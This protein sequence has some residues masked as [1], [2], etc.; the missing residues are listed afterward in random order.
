MNNQFKEKT[1][2]EWMKMGGKYR[3]QCRPFVPV[4]L[5]KGAGIYVWDVEGKRYIDFESGQICMSIGHSHPKISEAIV[6][7][8]NKIMQNGSNYTCVSE[9]LLAKKL[10]EITPEPF[11]KS[12]FACSGSEANEIALRMVKKYTGRFEI[13]AVMRNYHGSTFGSFAVSS[14]VNRVGYG[15]LMNGVYFIPAPYCYRCQFNECYPGCK[16]SCVDYA[17]EL[18]KRV[19]SGK[20]AA[21]I[22]ELL[23]SGGGVIVPPKEWI[24]K[25]RQICNEREMLMIA[26]EAQTGIGRTGKWFMCQHLDVTPDIITTSKSI[27]GGVP[28]SAVITSEEI[29]DTS[30]KNG[31]QYSSSHA[32]DP[33]L[34]A[35]GLAQIELIEQ[36]NLMNN[37]TKIENIMKKGLREL[38]EKY[39]VIGDVRGLGTLLGIEIVEDPV[40][41]K[42]AFDL[43]GRIATECL[44]RGLIVGCNPWRMPPFR[45][46]IRIV[47]P[48]ISKEEELSTALNIL[49]E[50]IKEAIK[51]KDLKQF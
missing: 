5:E 13:V 35:V 17:E 43:A 27:G 46:V 33:F 30:V 47:P 18:I 8:I 19:T 11:Q 3:I 10:A 37:A 28:L 21:I 14:T 4:V 26:D 9:I 29:A 32:G 48:F 42:P 22:L 25:I 31:F 41:K 20:P 15:P 45:N 49:E 51:K 2:D 39:E 50:G 36:N 23:I 40:S 7:Q 12:F 34:C 1:N 44:E 38:Q 16:L 6:N 24:Q